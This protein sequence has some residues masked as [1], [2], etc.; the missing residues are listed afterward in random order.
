[1]GPKIIRKETPKYHKIAPSREISDVKNFFSVLS[2]RVI[3]KISAQN[4]M[5]KN[6]HGSQEIEEH[7]LK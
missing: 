7:T 3:L 2:V 5:R 6:L 1:M 4:F